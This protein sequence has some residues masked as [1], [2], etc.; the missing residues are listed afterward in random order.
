MGEGEP[1]TEPIGKKP[2]ETVRVVLVDDAGNILML[3]KSPTSVGAGFSEFPGGNI[4]D[5]AGMYPTVAEQRRAALAEAH[6]ET[7]LE[8]PR[9]SL[10]KADDFTYTHNDISRNVHVFVARIPGIRPAF[11]FGQLKDEQGHP[12]DLHSGGRWV[13]RDELDAL[14]N[15]NRLL[16]NSVRYEKALRV[17]VRHG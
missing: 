10:R 14:K 2:R 3:D 16:G 15:D 9:K 12:L 1:H 6:E 17:A 11:S 13:S 5:M 8:I 7:G 4:D